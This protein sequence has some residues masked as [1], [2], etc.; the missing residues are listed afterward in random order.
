VFRKRVPKSLGVL[1][2]PWPKCH[3]QMRLTITRAVS[4]LSLLAIAC[5]NSSRPD[6][7]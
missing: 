5:A 6:P 1:T 7:C 2:R 4:G 3:I